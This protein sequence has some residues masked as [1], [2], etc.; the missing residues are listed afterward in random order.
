MS[1][2]VT[3]RQCKLSADQF[4]RDEV[5]NAIPNHFFDND[6]HTNNHLLPE[7][8]TDAGQDEPFDDGFLAEVASLDAMSITDLSGDAD[9]DDTVPT[10]PHSNFLMQHTLSLS[11]Q[12]QTSPFEASADS[13]HSPLS[14]DKQNS[15]RM[16]TVPSLYTRNHTN[17]VH[18]DEQHVGYLTSEL[19]ESGSQSADQQMLETNHWHTSLSQA[20]QTILSQTNVR[21]AS[22]M[23]SVPMRQFTPASDDEILGESS[24][25][26]DRGNTRST[27]H[28]GLPT[29]AN[30][31]KEVYKFQEVDH[32]SERIWNLAQTLS[33]SSDSHQLDRLP[34]P[35]D[36]DGNSDII[37]EMDEELPEII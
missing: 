20:E 37:M 14:A 5:A 31:S 33:V 15:E 3:E 18:N 21:M 35:R 36:P 28:A 12:Q 11:Q 6:S 19:D 13:H 10:A 4:L 7:R 1:D 8:M 2:L 32:V 22:L 9:F 26:D 23:K 25:D 29:I 24:N 34:S 27:Q 30:D 16:Q 17:S